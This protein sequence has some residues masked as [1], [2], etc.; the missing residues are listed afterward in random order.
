MRIEALK[1]RSTWIEAQ[2]LIKIEDRSPH[3]NKTWIEAQVK[4]KSEDQSP[5]NKINLDQSPRIN[6]K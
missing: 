5:Q 3:H 4:I 1:L 2:E 6:K